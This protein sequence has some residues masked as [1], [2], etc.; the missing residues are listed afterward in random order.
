HQPRTPQIS[1]LSLHDALP[2]FAADDLVRFIAYQREAGVEVSHQIGLQNLDVGIEP[3]HLG[4]EIFRYVG[5]A[6]AW[7]A[8]QLHEFVGRFRSEEHTSELQSLTNLVCRLL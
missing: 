8:G 3:G 6:R 2:I 5:R 4:A 7:T 1:T